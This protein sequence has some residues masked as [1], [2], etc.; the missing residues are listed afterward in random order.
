M[1]S[2]AIVVIALFLSAF[3]A[4]AQRAPATPTLDEGLGPVHHPVSTSNPEA[5]RWFDQGLAYVWAFNHE[6]AVASFTRAA[7]LDP[8]LAMAWWGVALAL[9]PNINMDVDPE[10]EK[11]AYDA[12]NQ[13]LLLR[14]HASDPE[15]GY[16]DA[17]A[18][19]YSDEADADL[20]ALSVDYSNAMRE[21]SRRYPDDLDLATLFAESV[22]DLH[23]WQ[24]WTLDGKP[25][26]GTEELIDTLQSVLK[27]NPSHVGANHYLIHTMEASPHPEV[28]LASAKRLET[29]APGAGHLVHM[30]GH[31][32][33]RTGDYAGAI[34]ANHK[35]IR[36]DEAFIAKHGS[37]SLYA[38]MY[39]GHNFQFLS[40]AAMMA[41][42][43]AE[44]KKA[45]DDMV[46][47]VGPMFHDMTMVQGLA[48]N[49]VLV[50]VRF[51]KWDDVIASA[52]PEAGP[53]AS[54]L[55]RFARGVAWARK[56]DVEAAAR[57]REAFVAERA[58]I[59]DDEPYMLNRASV[60][61]GVAANVLD[62]RI[63]EAGG[64]TED[65][66]ASY[67]QA[68][69]IEDTIQ[70][71][72]PSDWFYPVRETLGGA[73]LRQKRWKDAEAVFRAD[74]ERNPR[75]GRSLFGLLIALRSENATYAASMI[76]P[77][78]HAA[79]SISDTTLS[80]DDL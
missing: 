53:Q 18:K 22:M 56:G 71:D 52:E 1:R 57:E 80:V 17:L 44:A 64:R 6:M 24:L 39:G 50:L 48:A 3:S 4:T 78:Y 10:H 40:A 5:Q 9:G 59:A 26:D 51:A 27:R 36:A 68:V 65:A 45:A 67:E 12:V 2:T 13:A 32:Y 34:E 14:G 49:P 43:F 46:L 74:L 15:R 60:I 8:D 16:I 31:I 76:E 23:A 77:E 29:L 11:A 66:I 20:H 21:L 75:N 69:A 70:Y 42:R 58:K 25:A 72:E 33:I 35:G 47:H 61:L 62:G 41:G 37:N 38:M 54:A 55:W 63:A 7:E 79:W 28:A 19:R 30:P 73:M